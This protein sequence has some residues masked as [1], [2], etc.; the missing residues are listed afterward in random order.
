MELPTA[1][2]RTHRNSLIPNYNNPVTPIT[3]AGEI[4]HCASNMKADNKKRHYVHVAPTE[5]GL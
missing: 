2:F 4:C 1:R 3:P 5:V